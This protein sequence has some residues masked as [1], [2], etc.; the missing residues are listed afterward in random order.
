MILSGLHTVQ[1]N[2]EGSIQTVQ[3]RPDRAMPFNIEQL[4][5]PMVYV[6]IPFAN[7]HSFP[8]FGIILQLTKGLVIKIAAAQQGAAVIEISRNDSPLGGNP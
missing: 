1:L 7:L 3:R 5:R 8:E 2:L 4:I 6:Q